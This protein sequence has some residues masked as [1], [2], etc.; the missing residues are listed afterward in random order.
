MIPLTLELTNFLSYRSTT[1]LDLD[2]IHLACVSGL[3]GAGK[4]SLLDAMTWALFGKSRSK[5]DD[6]VVNRIAAHHGEMAEVRFDFLLEE[7]RYRV[8]RQKQQGRTSALEL[9]MAV[10]EEEWRTMTEGG[11][12]ATQTAIEQLLRMNFETFINASF[13][14]QGQA[15][16]FTTKTPGKRKEIL[17]DLLSVNRWDRY[18][19]AARARRQ[20]EEMAQAG[21]DA[22]LQSIEEELAEE[23]TRAEE[24]EAARARLATVQEQLQA[25]EK[26]LE[27]MRRVETALKQQRQQVQN[28]RESL[29][30]AEGRLLKLKQNRER[31][32]QE[33]DTYR[34][35]L[36]EAETI[37]SAY[38]AWQEAEAQYQQWQEKAEQFHRLQRERRPHE[39]A[40]ERARTRLSQRQ[41]EL[42]RQ[43][44]RVA[45]MREQESEVA[46]TVA[47][48]EEALATLS[49]GLEA[50]AAQ[51]TSWHQARE[52]LQKHLSQRKLWQQ[53][54]E[55]LQIQA[56]RA[57]RQQAEQEK[58]RQ[59]LEE[60]QR[61][62]ARLDEESLA[63]AKKRERHALALADLN[64]LEGEQPRLRREMDKLQERI[65]K[66]EEEAAG[67]CPLCGQ[68][69]TEEHRREV[70]AGIR[71]EGSQKGEHFRQN[72][73]QIEALRGEVAELEQAIKDAGRLEREQQSQQQRRA[74]AQA[75]LEEIER[76]LAEWQDGGPE[77]L[78]TLEQKLGDDEA[79]Q[80]RQAEVERLA[81]QVEEKKGLAQR[82]QEQQKQL[83]AAEARLA[84]IRR[85]VAEWEEKGEEALVSIRAKLADEDLAPEAQEALAELDRQLATL[86][87]DES[88][89]QAA[90]QTRNSLQEA[91]DRFQQLKQA[92]AAVR[93]LDDTLADLDQQVSEQEETVATVQA[94]HET[95]VAQLESLADDEGDLRT[96]EKEV[97]ALREQEIAVHQQV[98]AAR[99][100]LAVLDALRT[101]R[102][103][104]EERR[105]EISRR[106]QRLKLLEKACGRD[107]VQALLIEQALPEIEEDA[108]NLLERLTGGEMRIIFKTQRELKS[109]DALAE[110]LDIE[111]SDGVGV[112]PYENFSGGEQFRVNFAIRL[113]LSK[114]LARRAGAR[115]QTLVIDEGFGS[116]DPLGRQRLVEAINTIRG[117]FARILVITHIDALR[118]AFPRRIEVE[119]G[120]AGSTLNVV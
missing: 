37:Q 6:D 110:T 120:P 13:F 104:Q 101:Q 105:A 77:R 51:E 65:Q 45:A 76:A 115:L 103:Q 21:V 111:I 58:V 82:Q 43:Q 7:V 46:Q 8:I 48:H 49:T 71:V 79:L 91:P 11:V 92:E 63:L 9:Q 83:S 89:H 81:R 102:Q 2:G 108:N 93:P 34:E 87:Y 53:E 62:L 22:R 52:S 67:A 113:A 117:D 75:R 98:G 109:R 20:Q 96:V 36:A 10:A 32:R 50:L 66:L 94:Q 90:R 35:L 42:E 60:A 70:L 73:M 97:T 3:N 80:A 29:T 64:R 72:K 119:K 85:A 33:R 84:E 47:R 59:N 31:R 26:L 12:R 18:R 14:L 106:I 56:R 27:Q 41:S 38:A 55:Q 54:V 39:L 1:V 112:R 88:A 86:S 16:E 25:Q 107:G 17:A 30:R 99:Q 40:L 15:D 69:L 57:Q 68:P 23:E 28:L 19:D 24:L 114:I 61:A 116:Q 74:T 5:S 95:A 100:R 118:D 44:A 4:S 78:A